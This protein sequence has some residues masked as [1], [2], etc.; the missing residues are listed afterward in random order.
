MPNFARWNTF[1]IWLSVA[2]SVLALL[3]NFFSEQQLAGLP[4]WVPVQKVALGLDL[5]GGSHFT[6][7]IERDDIIRQRLEATIA[8]VG[9]QLR[10]SDIRYSGLSGVGQ[11]VQVRISDPNQVDAAQQAL[12]PMTDII[13]TGVSEIAI[14]AGQGGLLNLAITDKGID[15]RLSAALDQS[16]EV[17]RRRVAEAGA[18]TPMIDR[19][20]ADRITLQVPGLSD[21]QRLKTLL[22]QTAQLSFRF[23]DATVAV[24]DAIN[25][26]PPATSE[27]LYSMDDP[28]VA[29]LVEKRAFVTSAD[30]VEAQAEQ[31]TGTEDYLVSFRLNEDGAKRLSDAT[32]QGAGRTLAIVLD[33]QVLSTPVIREA[34][35]GATGQIS[36]N[37][38]EEGARDLAA[39]LRSGALPATLTVVEERT[40]DS[41]LGADS[42]N[43]GLVAGIIAAVAVFIFMFVFYGFLGLIANVALVANIVMI[44]A[45]LSIFGSTLTLPGIAGIVLTMGMAVDSNVLIYERIREEVKNGK[46]VAQAANTGFLRAFSTIIDANLTTLI[47]AVILFFLGTGPV[48]GFAV[49]VSIGILTTV[50]TAFALTRWIVARW[51]ARRHPTALPRG[52]RTGV[53]DGTNIRFMGIRR[54]TFALSAFL[55]IASLVGFTSIGM[56]VGIDFAGGSIIEVKARDGNADVTDI[57]ARLDELNL[58]DIRARTIGRDPQRVLIRV[59]AQDGGENAEQSA[60]TLIRG[61]LEETYEFRRVE[62]VGPAVSGELTLLATLGVLA[63]LVAV[64]VYIWFRFEWQFA[65]GAIIATLHDVILTIGLFVFTGMEFNLT[66][67]AALL[68]VVGYSLNDTVVVYDRMREN[69]RRYRDMPLPILIDSS[70]NQTLSRTILTGATTMLALA[71]LYIFGGEVIRSFAFA[72]LFGVAVGT[73]SSIYMAAPVLIAFRLRPQNFRPRDRDSGSRAAV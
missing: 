6:L 47:A 41:G 51:I 33:G 60:I 24:Q 68:T 66:S 70:I 7:K 73:F 45:V 57:L 54:F 55:A 52:V 43:S 32:R 31:V 53:F 28:P 72:M 4:R 27:V 69:L 61:E 16:V 38:S 17:V 59:Q 8:E 46:S 12:R 9:A 36:A 25:G 50:F 23:V 26:T 58:G 62:V 42:I 67:I 19:D 37:F 21:P 3:P 30:I 48:R 20:G 11:S 56:N 40:I 29:S 34:I 18:P 14:T 10:A 35:V 15:A 64:V 39:L 2:V 49:T 44:I 13:D 65:F 63:S 71:A 5:Q 1:L 22:D